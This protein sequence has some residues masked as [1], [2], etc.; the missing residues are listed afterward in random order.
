ATVDE[1][2]TAAER[3]LGDID[4]AHADLGKAHERFLRLVAE[5]ERTGLWAGDGARD[6]SQWLWMRY[7]ISD[8]KA[9]R[10]IETAAALPQLPAITGALARGELGIDKVIELTRFAAFETEDGLVP[11]AQH[12]SAARIRHEAEVARKP[13]TDE[14]ATDDQTRS[15]TWGYR[16]EGRRFE[17]HADLPAAQGAAV[18]KAIDRVAASIPA[19]PDEPGDLHRPARRADALVGLCSARLADD[20]DQDRATVV[21]HARTGERADVRTGS[22]IEGGGIAHP[23]TLERLL[24]AARVETVHEGT[25]GR[26]VGVGRITRIPPAWLLRQVRY[27]DGGCRFP[28]CGTKAFTQAHHIVFWREGGDTD[29][30]NLATLCSWHHKLV[31]EYGWWIKGSAQSELRWYRPDGTRYRAGPTSADADEQTLPVAG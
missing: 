2:N 21:I 20:P 24:C 19:M 13:D 9:R 10:F 3:L 26:V 30:D 16:D 22:E 14:A 8:W 27:R 1:R 28:G 23:S 25:D 6:L 31:H 5:V 29:L 11:W 18:A 4:R 7:G 17:L 15:L 12:V